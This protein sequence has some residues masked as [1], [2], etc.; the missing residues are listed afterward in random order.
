MKLIKEAYE[1]MINEMLDTDEE[2]LNNKKRRENIENLIRNNKKTKLIEVLKIGVPHSM[3]RKIYLYMMG[4][5]IEDE[6]ENS[7]SSDDSVLMIDYFLLDDLKRAVSNENYFLFEENLKHV[8]FNLVRDK[9]I[10]KEI[11]G[12]RPVILTSL[13][14]ISNICVPY[15]SSGLIPFAGISSQCSCFTYMSTKKSEVYAITKNFYCKYLSFTS[16]FTT[17]KNSILSLIYNFNSLM[18]S[19]P[20]LQDLNNVLN[21]NNFDINRT[22][23][24]WIFSSFADVVS[25]DNVFI[26]YDITILT[27][28][29]FVYVLLSLSLL[30]YRKSILMTLL[31]REEISN[32]LEFIKYESISVLDVMSKFFANN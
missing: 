3:R 7:H 13:A 4:I 27:D 17:H 1:E 6:I 11:Q 26:I 15:P 24:T 21:R 23:M 32:S 25:P 29:L 2:I 10:L 9:D 28:S 31:T 12:V 20:S 19:T 14:K 18:E 16:S 22:V 5:D 8:L 30:F